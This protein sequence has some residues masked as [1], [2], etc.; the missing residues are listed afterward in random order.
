MVRQVFVIILLCNSFFRIDCQTN[1]LFNRQF[2]EAINK[3]TAYYYNEINKN[4]MCFDLVKTLN[5]N[6]HLGY[7]ISKIKPE[8][9]YVNNRKYNSSDKHLKK[10]SALIFEDFPTIKKKLD[11]LGILL[12]PGDYII[13]LS[14]SLMDENSY[15][16]DNETFKNLNHS[17]YNNILIIRKKNNLI[18]SHIFNDE[19]A[20]RN[21][22]K[23]GDT[24][25]S[26]NSIPSIF[27]TNS[28]LYSMN[29][30]KTFII[31]TNNSLEKISVEN[32]NYSSSYPESIDIIDSI[33][34]YIVSLKILESGSV[35]K[36]KKSLDTIMNKPI[37]FDITNCQG[38][39]LTEII[40]FLD[41][42]IAKDNLL[43]SIENRNNPLIH[44][45]VSY[46]SK[47]NP[48]LSN[49]EFLFSI[50]ENTSYGGEIIA[51]AIK[52]YQVSKIVGK[53]TAGIDYIQY[54]GFLDNNKLC[55][56]TI[57]HTISAIGEKIQNTG[58]KPDIYVPQSIN[59][60]RESINILEKTNANK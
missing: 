22:I 41:L 6:F 11:S 5:E 45:E 25:L 57:A 59:I 16:I 14:Y 38:G 36:F 3:F 53:R 60:L 20:K 43:F 33:S 56:I 29:K 55:R 31:E 51:A 23:I 47:Q 28:M 44:N 34:Y 54:N 4:T 32:Y 21:N 39:I 50:S 8:S 52:K 30:Q 1:D 26:I 37:I 17:Y 18:I 35:E 49:Y 42:F 2:S 15:V 7:E 24:V 13:D 12:T 46:F 58:V 48:I 40:D 19:W 27:V 9:F 10:L